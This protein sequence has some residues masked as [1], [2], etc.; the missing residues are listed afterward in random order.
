MA[1]TLEGRSRAPPF[2]LAHCWGT[3]LVGWA[4]LAPSLVLWIKGMD[5]CSMSGEL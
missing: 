2:F 1:W 5:L 3:D 4:L